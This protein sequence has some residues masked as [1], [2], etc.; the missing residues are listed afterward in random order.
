LES[1]IVITAIP[2]NTA[3]Y[4]QHCREHLEKSRIETAEEELYC[5]E[6]ENRLTSEL[7]RRSWAGCSGIS[8]ATSESTSVGIL[9]GNYGTF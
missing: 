1:A 9:I 3:F 5:R 4:R 6:R 8:N 7:I 2:E